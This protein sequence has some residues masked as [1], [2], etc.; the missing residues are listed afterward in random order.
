MYDLGPEE[1]RTLELLASPEDTVVERRT[2][3]GLRGKGLVAL[4]ADGWGVTALGE[5]ALNIELL[6]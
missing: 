2:L 3:E 4:S 1:R 5:A 6:D